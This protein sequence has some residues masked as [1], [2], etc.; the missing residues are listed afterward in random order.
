MGGEVAFQCSGLQSPALPPPSLGSLAGAL[1]FSEA[2]T[3]KAKRRRLDFSWGGVGLGLSLQR[4]FTCLIGGFITLEALNPVLIRTRV[5][6]LWTALLL[7]IPHKPWPRSS[8]PL[9]S[10]MSHLGHSQGLWTRHFGSF[11]SIFFA[12]KRIL[13]MSLRGCEDKI[14]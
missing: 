8:Q 7:W 4:P 1:Q 6:P 13:R 2:R 14:N 3:S 10:Q 12:C 9:P 11:R 5:S